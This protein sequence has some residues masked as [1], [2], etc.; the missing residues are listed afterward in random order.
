MTYTCVCG[1]GGG[2]RALEMTYICVGV[3]HTCVC[4]CLLGVC[5]VSV[6][7]TC[8][9]ICHTCV[10]YVCWGYHKASGAE[11]LNPVNPK[12]NNNRPKP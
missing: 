12:P 1:G 5:C 11:V 10:V 3:R 8:V 7:H 4:I 2:K 6:C 9:C